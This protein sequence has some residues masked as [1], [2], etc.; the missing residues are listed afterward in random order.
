MSDHSNHMEYDG[1]L[2]ALAGQSIREM[3]LVHSRY[4]FE[5]PVSGDDT[6]L[7]EERRDAHE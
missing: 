5:W 1:H 4:G 2:P 3:E 7:E 6:A